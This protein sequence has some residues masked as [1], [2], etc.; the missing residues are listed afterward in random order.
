MFNITD[1]KGIAYD[2]VRTLEESEVYHLFYPEKYANETMYSDPDYD[3]VH[4]ELKSA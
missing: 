1:E 4:Q 3:H 2:D